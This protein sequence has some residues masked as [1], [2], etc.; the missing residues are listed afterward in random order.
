MEKLPLR[1]R[2]LRKKHNLS[3]KQLG[4][5]LNISASAYGFYEQG[6]NLPPIDTIVFLANYYNVSTDYLLGSSN[7]P[8]PRAKYY[9]DLEILLQN[10]EDNIYDNHL[11]LSLD[12]RILDRDLEEDFLKDFENMIINTK[13]KLQ[14]R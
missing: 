8:Q 5:L 7:T 3:Q 9:L 2:E 11:I 10:L 14:Q 1:F 4:N 6:K 13:F 12:G